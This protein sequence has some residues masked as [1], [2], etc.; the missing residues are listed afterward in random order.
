MSLPGQDATTMP[1]WAGR[2][3]GIRAFILD[4]DGV[5]TD[6]AALHRRAWKETFDAYLEA[7]EGEDFSPFTDRDYR[8]WVDGKPRYRGAG[9]FL[10]SRGIDLPRGEPDDP[11]DRETVC[12]I[13]NRKD[14][15]FRALLEE[16]GVEPIEGAGTWIRLAR[17]KGFRTGIVTSSRNGRRVLRAAGIEA[18]FDTRIDGEDGER[19]EL[20]GKPDPAYFLAAAS[21]LGVEP[22][23]AAVVE[24]SAAG[25]EAGRRGEFGLVVGVAAED[26]RVHALDEA[27]A[28][29]VVA[30]LAGIP[31]LQPDE[32]STD[33]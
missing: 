14:R 20:A 24:D 3:T 29:V 17:D 19:R 5:V 22:E 13:G 33:A 21:D 11:P 7:R 10:E 18:L 30:R 12:G 27:G 1:G 15:R 32:G 4:L 28:D 2:L 26:D 16:E 8:R 25:V 9:T 31:L 23:E 6:T